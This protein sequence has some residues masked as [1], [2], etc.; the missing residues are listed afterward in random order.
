MERL[1]KYWAW[2]KKPFPAFLLG[3]V[4]GGAIVGFDLLSAV[5]SL[6]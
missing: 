2:Q 1:K 6:V 5:L 4:T 3:N